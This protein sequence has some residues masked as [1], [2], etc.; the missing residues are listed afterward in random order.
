MT[1]FVRFFRPSPSLL[2]TAPEETEVFQLFP[3]R[4]RV[5][6]P[7]PWTAYLD[8]T[9]KTDNRVDD[10]FETVGYVVAVFLVFRVSI[11]FRRLMYVSIDFQQIVVFWIDALHKRFTDMLLNEDYEF[12]KRIRNKPEYDEARIWGS[13][14]FITSTKGVW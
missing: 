12:V 4:V 1:V 5:E 2:F 10:F 6:Y 13:Y 3:V 7:D 8:F 11:S 14:I 9:A